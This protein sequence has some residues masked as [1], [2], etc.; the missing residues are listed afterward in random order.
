MQ[1]EEQPYYTP[2]E[3]EQMFNRTPAVNASGTATNHNN[4]SHND[5]DKDTYSTAAATNVYN[6]PVDTA[7]LPRSFDAPFPITTDDTP[8]QSNKASGSRR[9]ILEK[10]DATSED[11]V[12][13]VA[14]APKHFW[15]HVIGPLHQRV[16]WAIQAWACTVHRTA[17]LV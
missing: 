8:N 6:R 3:V 15:L 4:S 13:L 7:E 11:K 9:R 1:R 12:H 14:H 16:W 17:V 10:K 5:Q 2:E